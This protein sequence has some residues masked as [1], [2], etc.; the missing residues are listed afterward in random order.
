MNNETITEKKARAWWKKTYGAKIDKGKI[1]ELAKKVKT[2]DSKFDDFSVT[3]T[4]N[5]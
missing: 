1:Q 5:F 4:I 2:S 3:S